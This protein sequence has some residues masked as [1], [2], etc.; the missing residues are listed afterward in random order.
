MENGRRAGDFWTE[1]ELDVLVA[2]LWVVDGGVKGG[3]GEIEREREV[4]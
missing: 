1:M 2:A 4:F 3:D